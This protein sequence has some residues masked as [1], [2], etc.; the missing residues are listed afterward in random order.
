[1]EMRGEWRFASRDT[2]EQS[3]MIHGITEMLKLYVDNLDLDQQVEIRYSHMTGNLEELLLVKALIAFGITKLTN[4][5]AR[6][7]TCDKFALDGC[8]PHLK[9]S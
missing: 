8:N 5:Q 3:A 9:N 4:K 1:M 7:Y 2:G 6:L